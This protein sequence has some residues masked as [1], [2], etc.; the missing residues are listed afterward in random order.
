VA[1]DGPPWNVSGANQNCNVTLRH[2]AV[3]GNVATGYYVKPDC[4][5]VLLPK[6][7]YPGANAAGAPGVTSP[8][9]AGRHVLELTVLCRGNLV[10]PDGTPSLLTAGQWHT[11]LIAYMAQSNSAIALVD[12]S[13]TTWTVATEEMED[14][15]SPSGGLTLLEWETRVVFVEL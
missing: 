3:N 10:H 7:W 13:G 6:A 11:S 8:L 14:R 5:R 4:F 12:P 1:S 15:H 9:A 2:A